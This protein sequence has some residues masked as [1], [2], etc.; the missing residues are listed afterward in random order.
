MANT[1][2][3][4]AVNHEESW[5]SRIRDCVHV[6]Q[7]RTAFCPC[8]TIEMQKKRSRHLRAR[9]EWPAKKLT[10]TSKCRQNAPEKVVTFA[11][12]HKPLYFSKAQILALATLHELWMPKV[13]VKPY[14]VKQPI[15]LRPEMQ[16]KKSAR[17][18]KIY[19]NYN[20]FD[21]MPSD[22]SCTSGLESWGCRLQGDISC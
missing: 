6:V 12:L 3:G 19:N 11:Q 21:H 20:F 14:L 13:Y 5:P 16:G 22:L 2:K 7:I 15:Q 4:R 8:K 18:C 10:R 1:Y 9:L 17:V